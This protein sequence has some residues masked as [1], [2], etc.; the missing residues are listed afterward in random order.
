MVSAYD[1]V[2]KGG[3][4]WLFNG[5]KHMPMDVRPPIPYVDELDDPRC[6]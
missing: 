1:V 2:E 5:S 3:F 6:A 4:V